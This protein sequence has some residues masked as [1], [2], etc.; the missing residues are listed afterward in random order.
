MSPGLPCFE[1]LIALNHRFEP[2]FLYL[3]VNLSVRISYT[4]VENLNVPVNHSGS[5]PPAMSK[6]LGKLNEQDS[7]GS[8]S[9]CSWDASKQPR[10]YLPRS[11]RLV[12][13]SKTGIGAE[14]M[15]RWS[16]R[17][18]V[19]SSQRSLGFIV[20]SSPPLAD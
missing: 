15:L 7:Q 11:T 14:H 8:G 18:A 9:S 4:H 10:H 3:K 1:K 17:F 16:V 5:S 12:S 20:P 19:A 6:P 13:G 2:V